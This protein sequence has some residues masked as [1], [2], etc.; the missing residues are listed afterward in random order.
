MDSLRFITQSK[1]APVR[2]ALACG[3]LLAVVFTATSRSQQPSTAYTVYTE[4]GTHTLPVRTA[5]RTELVSLGLLAD[6]F[7]LTVTED[8]VLEGLTI[9]ARDERIVVI[10]G[11]SF[12]SIG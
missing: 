11:Q 9:A 6:W 10:P 7:D 8:R 1:A 2:V 5:G 4:D 3:V 12:V